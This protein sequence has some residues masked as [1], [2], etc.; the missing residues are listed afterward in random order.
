MVVIMLSTLKLVDTFPSVRG[1]WGIGNEVCDL[2]VCDIT[3]EHDV[4]TEDLWGL[5]GSTSDRWWWSLW[6]WSLCRSRWWSKGSSFVEDMELDVVL[7]PEGEIEGLISKTEELSF[8]SFS[9][10]CCFFSAS[11]K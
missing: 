11:E 8:E 10:S 3:A 5:V 6:R 4:I 9:G 1:S 7:V 2:A